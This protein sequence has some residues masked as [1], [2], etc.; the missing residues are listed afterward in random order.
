[1][2]FAISEAFSS[3]RDFM[4]A[5]GSVL[6]LIA[7]LVFAMWAMIF[8]RIWFFSYG[9]NQYISVQSQKWNN[10]S[11][12]TSWHALQIREKIISQA[13]IEISKNLSII[14]TCV[15]LAPLFGLLGTVTGMIEVFQVMAFNGGGDARAMAGGV[16][17]ATLPTM[18]GMVVA[19]SGVFA[20]IYL[21]SASEKHK[22]DLNEIIKREI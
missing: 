4:E 14:Q 8:E 15:M 17:K 10:R 18:A 11:D 9:Y 19:L 22:T 3:I 7:I 6:W 20:S 13:K 12:K 21:N 16:S 2:F 1:M 5:G